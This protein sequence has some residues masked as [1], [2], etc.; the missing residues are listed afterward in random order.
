MSG[1][2]LAALPVECAPAG[3]DV[4][5]KPFPGFQERALRASADELLLGGAKGGGKTRLL[6]AMPLRWCHKPLAAMAFVRES[7]RELERPLDEAHRFYATLPAAYRPVWTGHNSRFTWPSGAFLRF[8]YART[9][10]DVTWTQGGNWSHIFYDEVGNQ[11]NE[12]VVDTLISE[13]RCPDPTIRR[14]FVGSA[15]PGFAGHPWIKRRFIV[16]CGKQGERIAWSRFVLPTGHVVHRSR[17]FVPGRVTDN[18]IYANDAA[19]MATLMGL[20]DRMRRCLFDGDWDAA[21]GMA[22]DELNPNVHLVPPFQCP[23]HWPWISAFDWGFS[24]WSFFGYGRVSDD[25]RVFIVNTLKRRLLRDWDLAGTVLEVVPHEALG[26]VHAGHDCFGHFEGRSQ[27][28]RGDYTKTTAE[29]FGEQGINLVRANIARVSGYRNVL[30]YLAWQATPFLPQR[31]P[32]VQF[33]DTPHNRWLVEEHL[34]SMVLD[35]DDPSDV[36]KVDADRE[37]GSGG[38][39]GYD[40]LRYLLA[41]RPMKAPT[42]SYLSRQSAW[43]EDVLRRLAEQHGRVD[44]T[45]LTGKIGKPLVRD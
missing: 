5:F 3:A 34:S 29:Y 23:E 35:P 28:P 39:D 44:S 38:D 7:F 32:M 45:K 27:A 14:Q 26:V 41:S 11:A 33:F 17:Q 20:P 16:P 43:D 1:L 25:G 18:P 2:P 4:L 31:Q 13:I 15:N 42:L 40:W 12:K 19:Y 10:A 36:L 6:L 9:V 24:H 22:L 37:D 21:S 30:Q 8:G